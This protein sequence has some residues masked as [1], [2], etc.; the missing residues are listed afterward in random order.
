MKSEKTSQNTLS[1]SHFS[2]T[3]F[4]LIIFFCIKK[5]TTFSVFPQ[6][7]HIN[8]Y[9]TCAYVKNVQSKE[10]HMKF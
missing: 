8:T 2:R 10:N 5:Q 6:H 7:S 1:F 4:D 9:I 3:I